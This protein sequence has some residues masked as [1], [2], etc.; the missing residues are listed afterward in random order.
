MDTE[1]F[2]GIDVSKAWLDIAIIA[3]QPGALPARLANDEASGASL[4]QA[5]A[6]LR[7]TLV[8]LEATGG[9]ESALAGQ[10]YAAGVPVAVLN[11]KRVRDFARAAGIAAKTDRL[12]ARVLAQFAQRM[13]PQV[14]PM[15][16]EAQQQIT[17]LVDRRAQLVAMRAQEKTRLA[18]VKPVAL[19]SVREHIVWLDKRIGV[20]WS[21]LTGHLARSFYRRGQNQ[22]DRKE[23]PAS[24]RCGLQAAGGSDDSRAGPE[25]GASLPRHEP[26]G[27]C[28]AAL[29]GAVR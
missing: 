29:G 7:V 19:G 1:I 15:P 16:D 28:R 12:D 26:G 23:I 27:E 20:S 8:V 11:P 4:A 6:A 17:E 21:N 18:T 10:L 3:E 14:Y 5:L 22:H 2:V 24:L 9:W 25:R 13:R